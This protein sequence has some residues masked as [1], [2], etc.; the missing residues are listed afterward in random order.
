MVGDVNSDGQLNAKDSNL[1]KQFISGENVEIRAENADINNDGTISS[2]DANLL[3]Q[4]L[5]GSL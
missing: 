3:K 4:I 5:S 2:K 1:L